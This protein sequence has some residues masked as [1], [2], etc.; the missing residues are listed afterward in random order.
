M[1]FAVCCLLFAV[2]CLLFAVCCLLLAACCLLL[3]AG[4]WLL[5][6]GWWLVAGGWWLVAGC[7]SLVVGRWSL[8]V[9]CWL[10][11]V[12]CW[13][14]LFRSSGHQVHRVGCDTALTFKLSFFKG[15]PKP[16]TLRSTVSQAE[17]CVNSPKPGSFVSLCPSRATLAQPLANFHPT[18]AQRAADTR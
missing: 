3:A 12:G 5:A 6:A 1:L 9:G 4:C 13:L 8:V 2:C 17:A 18:A 7:C 11:V 15:L 14:L 10:L 16:H